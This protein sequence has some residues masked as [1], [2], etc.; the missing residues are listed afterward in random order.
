VIIVVFEESEED[1]VVMTE[2]F[3][4]LFFDEYVP[5]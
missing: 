1:E 3:D 4:E 5:K 2:R